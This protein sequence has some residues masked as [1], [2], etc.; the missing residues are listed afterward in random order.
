MKGQEIYTCSSEVNQI[1]GSKAKPI[2]YIGYIL[3]WE[4]DYY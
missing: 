4:T 2:I 3:V 1:I